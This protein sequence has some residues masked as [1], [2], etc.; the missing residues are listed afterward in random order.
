MNPV[1]NQQGSLGGVTWPAC[2]GG[3]S[4]VLLWPALAL[5]GPVFGR[6]LSRLNLIFL[7][8]SCSRIAESSAQLAL[9]GSRE[10]TN[11]LQKQNIFQGEASLVVA[12]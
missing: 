5:F 10:E 11:P 6:S 2:D 7:V 1:L 4:L 9:A 12:F 8:C 3:L